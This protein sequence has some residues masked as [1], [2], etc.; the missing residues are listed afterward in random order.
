MGTSPTDQP[1]SQPPADMRDL[2]KQYDDVFP[3]ELPNR[4]PPKRPVDHA[5]KVE[6]GAQFTSNGNAG[7]HRHTRLYL[8]LEIL[9]ISG[10]KCTN[11]TLNHATISSILEACQRI[12]H[13]YLYHYTLDSCA[14][15]QL[16]TTLSS[17][18]LKL[19]YLDQIGVTVQHTSVVNRLLQEQHTHLKWISL[20]RE[21]LTTA[22]LDD[23]HDSLRQWSH[24]E[25][26][27]F[28]DCGL[29]SVSLPVLASLLRHWPRLKGLWLSF[30]VHLMTEMSSWILFTCVVPCRTWNFQPVTWFTPSSSSS[31]KPFLVPKC[32]LC[33]SPLLQRKRKKVSP[34]NPQQCCKHE[35]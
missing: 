23:I 35:V 31:W 32:S 34:K 18:K 26:V 16:L 15:S 27:R 30:L 12:Q 28:W 7:V 6:E 20:S 33:T 10:A 8:A 2:L 1:L 24:L 29:L 3:S 21:S 11:C 25:N 5:I 17:L 22:F 4:L 13:F 19:L 9:A 14:V